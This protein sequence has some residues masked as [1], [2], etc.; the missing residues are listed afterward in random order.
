MTQPRVLLDLDL[1]NRLGVT[2]W[3]VHPLRDRLSNPAHPPPLLR[4]LLLNVVPA[5]ALCRPRSIVEW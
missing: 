3:G 4:S 2:A 5:H 1:S